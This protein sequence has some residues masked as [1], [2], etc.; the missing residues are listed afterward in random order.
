MNVN[1]R[2]L[3][4]DDAEF[5]CSIFKENTEYY[6][7]F[8]DS[9]ACIDAWQERVNRFLSQTDIS[10]RIITA[11]NMPVGWFSYMKADQNS[12]EIGILVL[13]PAYL[14]QGYGAAA[15][16]WIIDKV[17]SEDCNCLFLNVNQSN[18]RAISFY[19]HFGFEICGEEIV[20]QCNDAENLP[21][22]KMRLQFK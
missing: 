7:I 19:Q 22:Y 17:R 2:P 1:I 16:R 14:G 10:Y 9:E 5:L 20:P 13:K 3:Q 12:F 18:T 4:L 6:H 8:F 15:L 11:N 21:Q